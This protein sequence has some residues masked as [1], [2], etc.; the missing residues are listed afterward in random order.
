MAHLVLAELPAEQHVLPVELV[1]EIHQAEIEVLE[2]PTEASDPVDLMLEFGD[3]ALE[4]LFAFGD[5]SWDIAAYGLR[6]ETEALE[7]V[8]ARGDLAAELDES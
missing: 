3:T 5:R 4:A 6:I 7:L 1:P 8:R 2:N